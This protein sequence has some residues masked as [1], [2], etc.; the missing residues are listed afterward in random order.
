MKYHMAFLQVSRI[1]YHARV[2]AEDICVRCH[3]SISVKQRGYFIDHRTVIITAPQ[4]LNFLIFNF[5]VDVFNLDYPAAVLLHSL[6]K[7][8]YCRQRV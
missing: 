6:I 5:T 2:E 1:L 7:R 8:Q 4:M 3:W